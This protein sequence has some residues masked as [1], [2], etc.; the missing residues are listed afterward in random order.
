VSTHKL[1]IMI[2]IIYINLVKLWSYSN[3]NWNYQSHSCSLLTTSSSHN[4]LILCAVLMIGHLAFFS[5]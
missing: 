2:I 4:S 1:S 5:T 3:H